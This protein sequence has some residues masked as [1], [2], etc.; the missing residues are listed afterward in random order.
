MNIDGTGLTPT[1]RESSSGIT[2]NRN[3]FYIGQNNLLMT[4]RDEFSCQKVDSQVSLLSKPS[5]QL[6]KQNPVVGEGASSKPEEDSADQNSLKSCD[7]EL[8]SLSM[9]LEDEE[10]LEESE[11]VRDLTNVLPNDDSPYRE[12]EEINQNGDVPLVVEDSPGDESRKHV[13]FDTSI[14]GMNRNKT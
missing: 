5:Q 13:R 12:C 10:C 1:R 3:S 4:G 2:P 6:M 14:T 7:Q 8:E 11:S 9:F